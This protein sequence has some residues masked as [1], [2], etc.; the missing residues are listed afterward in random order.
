MRMSP[1]EVKWSCQFQSVNEIPTWNCFIFADAVVPGPAPGR[2][3]PLHP[4]DAPQQPQDIASRRSFG[5]TDSRRHRHCVVVAAVGDA[6]R[7]E[8]D[9]VENALR[10]IVVDNVECGRRRV[11]SVFVPILLLDG[12]FC[13]SE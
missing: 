7:I 12:I 9:D 2:H 11:G 5:A 10:A 13:G 6:V 1:M 3:G 8:E 4:P